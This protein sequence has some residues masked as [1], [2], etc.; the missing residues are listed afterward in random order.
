MRNLSSEISE[1]HIDEK[2]TS[3][4]KEATLTIQPTESQTVLL[5]KE[6]TPKCFFQRQKEG[7]DWLKR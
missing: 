1:S 2:P 5:Q 3:L 7:S 6:E 4:E